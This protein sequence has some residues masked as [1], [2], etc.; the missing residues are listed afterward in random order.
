MC[1]N[2]YLSLICSVV[3]FTEAVAEE[4]YE[5]PKIYYIAGGS[6]LGLILIFTLKAICGYCRYVQLYKFCHKKG[7]IMKKSFSIV[8]YFELSSIQTVSAA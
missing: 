6:V 4:W 3:I 8:W 1:Y 7:L 2:F 5:N